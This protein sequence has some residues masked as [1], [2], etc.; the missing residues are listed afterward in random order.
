[1]ERVNNENTTG[2]EH[3]AG[4]FNANSALTLECLLVTK[5]HTYLNVFLLKAADLLFTYGFLLQI[6][7]KRSNVL[8]YLTLN[9]F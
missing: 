6:G 5:G 4:V 3:H 7:I 8:L 9:T 2:R 1:M